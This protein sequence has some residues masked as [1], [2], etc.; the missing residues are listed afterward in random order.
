MV[1]QAAGSKLP[2][3]KVPAEFTGARLDSFVGHCLP[4]LSRRLI[5]RALEA[6]FFLI[7]GRAGKKGDRLAAG[8]RLTFTGPADWLADRPMPELQLVPA[9][10]FEDD[11]MLALDKPAGVPTH[12]F[13]GRDIGT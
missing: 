3:W 11:S 10:I 5:H 13:S 6:K 12:G 9:V 2:T 7:D 8:V 4:H 1:D